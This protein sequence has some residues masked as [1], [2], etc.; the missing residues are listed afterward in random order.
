VPGATKWGSEI[1]VNTTTSRIQYE[2]ALAGL[3]DGR[4]VAVWSDTSNGDD[5]D[6]RARIINS[7]GT[8][9]AADVLVASTNAD[10]QY[11]PRVSALADGKFVVTWTDTSGTSLD[12]YA[13]IF[14]ADGS[15]AAAAFMVTALP[16]AHQFE[17]TV[18]TLADG[19]FVVAW[20]D[21]DLIECNVRARVFNADGSASSAEFVAHTT[22]ASVQFLPAVTALA[23][24]TFV[25]AVTDFS[26]LG[27]DTSELGIRAQAFNPDGTAAAAEFNVNTTTAGSQMRPAITAL[28][29]GTLVAVWEDYSR[30]TG[31]T[32]SGAIRA[33]LFD[34]AFNPLGADFVVNTTTTR[35]QGNAVVAALP[36]GGFVV[37]WEDSSETGGDR[38]DLAIRAQVFNADGTKS[39]GELVANTSTR[40]DQY[41][42]SIA[43]LSDGRFALGWAD[44]SGSNGDRGW[45]VRA[46][47]F[48]PRDGAVTFAG[49]VLDDQF[50]GT[51]SADTLGGA[52]GDDSLLGGAGNDLITG[53]NGADRLSGGAGQDT[54]VF[55]AGDGEDEIGDFA[56]VAGDTLQFTG[57][58]AAAVSAGDAS[59]VSASDFRGIALGATGATLAGQGDF[60]GDGVTDLAWRAADAQTTLWSMNGNAQTPVTGLGAFGFSWDF[61]ASGR[62][63]DASQSQLLLRGAGDGAMVLL[64]SQD[65]ERAA[66]FLGNRWNGVEHVAGGNFVEHGGT[67]MLIR[68]RADDHMYVWWIDHASNTLQGIDLGQRWDDVDLV[69]TADFTGDGLTDMLMRSRGDDHMQVWSVDRATS[70]LQTTDLGASWRH[71]RF[72]ATGDFT[73]DGSADM[74]VQNRH[75]DAL[76]VWQPQGAG[77]AGVNLL[78]RSGIELLA[79]GNFNGDTRT[80]MLVRNTADGHI[81][82]WWVGADG[83][84][85]G[86]DLGAFGAGWSVQGTDDY[87]GN[88]T[89]DVLWRNDATGQTALWAMS[90]AGFAGADAAGLINPVTD[91]GYGAGDSIR[92]DGV[93]RSQLDW[94]TDFVF[95]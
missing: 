94:A 78:P 2:P 93:H 53:G 38:D 4:L 71:V 6:V 26:R 43:V 63:D 11:E 83:S 1:L 34:A 84:L 31:D 87:D 42:P 25:V 62:F 60:D 90:G 23:D 48:D 82:E 8:S 58:T 41:D 10:H 7:D 30:S 73:G 18:T 75:D 57:I 86:V 5:V 28:A 79:S 77:L 17:P 51:A 14:N 49:T 46:Q 32:A 55:A 12:V 20:A 36:T 65:G 74:L 35:Y 33:R 61:V 22:T 80:E 85:Q 68:N 44:D 81:Y 76:Y 67:D 13:R 56:L 39:G 64:W 21:L 16:A 66:T 89:D 69:A 70:T 29:D 88:G 9:S 47:I 50:A 91:I 37:A 54:F 19:R 95:V 72:L 3:S 27:A 40:D 45:A 59:T 52:A 24:G 92:L 15:A